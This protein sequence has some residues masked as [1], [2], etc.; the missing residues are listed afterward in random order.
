MIL[1]TI[2]GR[3]VY[4]TVEGLRPV[5]IS[6]GYCIPFTGSGSGMTFECYTLDSRPGIST[7]KGGQRLYR[8]VRLRGSETYCAF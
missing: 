1:I 5:G 3:L 2:Q 4:V 7:F 8:E 6:Y